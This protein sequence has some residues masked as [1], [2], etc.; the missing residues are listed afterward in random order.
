MINKLKIL[1]LL[2]SRCKKPKMFNLKKKW[3][4]GI[5]VLHGCKQ[6]QGLD[7]IILIPDKFPLLQ[8]LF[9][10]FLI[11]IEEK[12]FFLVIVNQRY[13]H[14]FNFKGLVWTASISILLNFVQVDVIDYE[15]SFV[16]FP[17][18]KCFQIQL[19]SQPGSAAQGTARFAGLYQ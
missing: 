15:N 11:N 9:F 5:I 18:I 10:I 1:L 17:T 12:N 3:V 19:C 7:L 16:T 6:E 14:L 4:S 2:F 8:I 13:L